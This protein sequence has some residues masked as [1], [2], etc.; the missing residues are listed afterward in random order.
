MARRS[1]FFWIRTL[2]ACLFAI[3]IAGF[4]ALKGE[5][6]EPRPDFAKVIK[7]P[8]RQPLEIEIPI[9]S[10]STFALNLFASPDVSATLTLSGLPV[11]ESSRVDVR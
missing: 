2:R 6:D 9:R 7:L 3:L 10:G 4:I 5:A 1:H 8:A 11:P